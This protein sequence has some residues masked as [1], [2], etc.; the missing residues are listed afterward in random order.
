MVETY[1]APRGVSEAFS[2]RRRPVHVISYDQRMPQSDQLILAGYVVA[3]PTARPPGLDPLVPSPY[4]TVSSCLADDLRV[5]KFSGWFQDF[6]EANAALDE[7]SASDLLAVGLTQPD[8][9]TLMTDMAD[10]DYHFGLLRLARGMPAG[11]EMIGYEIVGAEYGLSFHTWHCYGLA[12]EAATTL[13]IQMNR[14]GLLEDHDD[15]ARTIDWMTSLPSEDAP[16]PVPWAAVAIAIMN[17]ASP[18]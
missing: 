13:G 3:G 8:A 10:E 1:S 11:A 16:A 18:D 17:Q 15:A 14:H 4:V 9:A 6:A 12:S 5:P 7:S 2:L